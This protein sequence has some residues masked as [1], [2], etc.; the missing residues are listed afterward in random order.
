MNDNNDWQ[1]EKSVHP[2]PASNEENITVYSSTHPAGNNPELPLPNTTSKKTRQVL[3]WRH[4]L[5]L[6]G[7]FFWVG[8]VVTFLFLIFRY[9]AFWSAF[10]V[11]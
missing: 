2:M 7:I 1:N 5:V 10:Y 4:P 3:T 8:C 9:F 6:V 11:F